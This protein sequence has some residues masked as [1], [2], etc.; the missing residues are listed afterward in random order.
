MLC[1]NM[2]KDFETTNTKKKYRSDLEVF[3]RES[4]LEDFYSRSGETIFVS[5]IHKAKGKEFDNVFLMLENIATHTDEIKRQLYVAITRAKQNLTIHLN[6]HHF[7]HINTVNLNHIERS[8]QNI[9][10]TQLAMQLTL[11]DIWLDYFMRTQQHISSLIAGDRLIVMDDGC[12]NVKGES[13]LK[14]SKSAMEQLKA[15]DTKGYKLKNATVDFIIYWQ[16]E[17]T[18]HEIKIVLPKLYFEKTG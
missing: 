1:E 9:E 4:K 2:I 15:M 7:D 3:I 8:G 13:I 6:T 5:T 10:P 17:D 16:K 14:F 11:K 18:Q 12:L